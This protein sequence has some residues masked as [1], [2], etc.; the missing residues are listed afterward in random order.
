MWIKVELAPNDLYDFFW[1]GAK[2]NFYSLVKNYDVDPEDILNVLEQLFEGGEELP[3]DGELN[4]AMWFE[5]DTI[6]EM[7]G[8]FEL[9]EYISPS[10]LKDILKVIKKWASPRFLTDSDVEG[11]SENEINESEA[12]EKIDELVECLENLEEY[13]ENLENCDSKDD[14]EDCKDEIEDTLDTMQIVKK[15]FT[16]ELNDRLDA[17]IIDPLNELL[18]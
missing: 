15:D 14:F 18:N 7:L 1:S 6:K 3:T 16:A 12:S 2:E 9:D 4:D 5:I 10:K 11:Y 8:V 13:L 17:D